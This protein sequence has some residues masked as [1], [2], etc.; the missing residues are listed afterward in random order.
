MDI[1][2][3]EVSP[4]TGNVDQKEFVTIIES[5]P[6]KVTT[7]L[8]IPEDQTEKSMIA[9]KQLENLTKKPRKKSSPVTSDNENTFIQQ[10]E[11]QNIT[12]ENVELSE[13]VQ[14]EPI[15]EILYDGKPTMSNL[16]SAIISKEELEDEIRKK[17]ANPDQQ[18]IMQKSTSYEIGSI[19]IPQE[20]ILSEISTSGDAKENEETSQLDGQQ[21]I[22]I[23][24]GKDDQIEDEGHII[25]V[26][27]GVIIVKDNKIDESTSYE[28]IS[29]EDEKMATAKQKLLER[30][31][32]M[33]Q[34][35][36]MPTRKNRKL[37][38]TTLPTT[39]S[40]VMSTVSPVSVQKSSTSLVQ[41]LAMDWGDD[42]KGEEVILE[43]ENVDEGSEGEPKIKILN[44]TILNEA[45]IDENVINKPA[46]TPPQQK[47]TP[48]IVQLPTAVFKSEPKILNK[49]A[50][51][52]NPP[53]ILN[54]NAPK[55]PV[56]EP[57]RV[58]KKKTIWDPSAAA[59][60]SSPTLLP[61]V[62]T[63]TSTPTSTEKKVTPS[64]K[65]PINLP[66]TIT[67]KKL[68]KE[69]LTKQAVASNEKGTLPVAT[70]SQQTT[71][72]KGKKKSEIDRLFQDEGAVNMIY[73]LER[74]NNNRDV[75]ELE[76]NVDKQ[77][78]IDKTEEKTKLMAKAKTIKQ[79]ILKQSSSPPETK[80]VQIRPQR[81]KRDL[82]PNKAE[83]LTDT[84]EKK[85]SQEKTEKT[86]IITKAQKSPAAGRKKKVDDSWDFVRNAQTTCDDAMIIRRHSNS[87][88]SS[89]AP[90]S[91]RRLSLDQQIPDTEESTKSNKNEKNGFKFTKPQEKSPEIQ[92]DLKS[93]VGG[94]VEELRN[95]LST[96]L[97]RG[98]ITADK[99][100]KG[101]KRTIASSN[102][103]ESP[104]TKRI[105]ERRS[106]GTE[107]EY[108]IVKEDAVSHII[109]T[110]NHL[111]ITLL[112][113]IKTLLGQL[114]TDDSC[115]VVLITSN[116]DFSHSLDYSTLFQTTVDKR[117]QAA[118]D[119]VTAMK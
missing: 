69:S 49:N 100:P 101:R 66:S 119:L 113:E 19:E 106:N 87:S 33:R 17:I 38:Q 74:R 102:Q 46:V 20:L 90:T 97:G 109:L 50:P 68:T 71:N 62:T 18:S 21:L 43:L 64:N 83:S 107:K 81:V 104:P 61:T 98:K 31:I 96:K 51:K 93:C 48:K 116:E 26:E 85:A 108:K 88:Y 67:I 57:K 114:E 82:T 95:T 22:D 77:S 65:L 2:S 63:A 79:T 8:Q 76:V 37:K 111:T 9:R 103:Q 55:T 78:M 72:K 25:E 6:K 14:Q 89:S 56:E 115:K 84:T 30:E 24:E 27:N 118:S 47:I 34:I 39:S 92:K 13:I 110:G 10:L 86:V 94:L 44:M 32:A 4:K 29:T 58:I 59:T 60:T 5:A 105:S 36:S 12:I 52:S 42:E 28:I 15:S 3:I 54:V 35:A 99:A 73:S 23:L 1:V 53:K 117:K 45:S 41:S 75:P 112:S 80:A 40:T 70:E 16:S 7:S 11:Q 91:P